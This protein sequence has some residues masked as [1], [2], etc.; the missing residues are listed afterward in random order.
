MG[1]VTKLLP[2]LPDKWAVFA[3][4]YLRRWALEHAW[5]QFDSYFD[6][7]LWYPYYHRVAPATQ[8]PDIENS[9]SEG[10]VHVEGALPT[11]V[12]RERHSE[13]E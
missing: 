13:T 1:W 8:H 5:Q 10:W 11:D 6:F 2:S 12:S 3:R 7:S 4:C 9:D